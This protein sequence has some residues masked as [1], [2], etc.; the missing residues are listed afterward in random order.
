MWQSNNSKCTYSLCIL[1]FTFWSKDSFQT[2]HKSIFNS[3]GGT[4][5]PNKN[6]LLEKPVFI[7]NRLHV[8]HAGLTVTK[9]QKSTPI[10]VEIVRM[11]LYSMHDCV[12]KHDQKVW[13]WASNTSYHAVLV[14]T[15]WQVLWFYSG[16]ITGWHTSETESLS[17]GISLQECRELL[18]KGLLLMALLLLVLGWSVT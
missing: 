9:L 4:S 7:S 11:H 10:R 14:H 16:G 5:R 15:P 12:S 8:V 13:A 17:Y 6:Q 2:F 3:L 1:N 18:L